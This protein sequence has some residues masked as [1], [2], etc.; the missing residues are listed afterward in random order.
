MR[1][2]RPATAG[3]EKKRGEGEEE[4]EEEEETGSIRGRNE[5]E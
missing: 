3:A 5:Q 2:H 1:D 4:E